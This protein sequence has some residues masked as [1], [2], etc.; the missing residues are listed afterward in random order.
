MANCGKTTGKAVSVKRPRFQVRDLSF[1][2]LL[3][4]LS[5]V[6]TRALSVMLIGGELVRVGLGS[7]PLMIAGFY[8]GPALGALSGFL[9]DIIGILINPMGTP[10]PGFTLTSVL[11]G[12]IPGL[13][14][15][16]F[17]GK[18]NWL[19]L[20]LSWFAVS[21]ICSCFLQSLWLSGMYANPYWSVFWARMTVVP[22]VQT[23]HI[24]I[25]QGLHPVLKRISHDRTDRF[26]H[27]R[28]LR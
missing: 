19:T 6:L 26:V 24:V 9:A 27:S 22:L 7:I 18:R 10:H 11:T 17:R 1:A 13:V 20:L 3:T 23:A 25:L 21:V 4:A 8:L 28:E 14:V 15:L 16:L 12:L 2:A 5:I